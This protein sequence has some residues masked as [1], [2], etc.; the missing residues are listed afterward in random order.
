M[1]PAITDPAASVDPATITKAADPAA[2]SSLIDPAVSSSSPDDPATSS[3]A[4]A[5]A[6]PST[7]SGAADPATSSS[8]SDPTTS[9]EPQTSMTSTTTKMETI[10]VDVTIT[11]PV[12]QTETTTTTISSQ[13]LLTCLSTAITGK[14]KATAVGPG[15]GVGASAALDLPPLPTIPVNEPPF[16][17]GKRAGD[18]KYGLKPVC[19]PDIWDDAE[20]QEACKCLALPPP[21]CTTTVTAASFPRPTAAPKLPVAGALNGLDGKAGGTGGLGG[22]SGILGGILRRLNGLGNDDERCSTVTSTATATNT[23]TAT[24]VSTTTK[25][26]T[27]YATAT[28]IVPNGLAYKNYTHP[29]DAT[30]RTNSN[31]FTSAF[32][33]KR[34]PIAQ[35]TLGGLSFATPNW[36]SGEGFTATRGGRIAIPGLAGEIEN[37]L[38]TAFLIQ[39]FFI[40]TMTGDYTFSSDGGKIDNWGM[41]WLGEPA[42]CDWDDANAAFLASRTETG[43]AVGGTTTLTLTEGDAVPLT[44][45]WANG[46]GAAR[47]HFSLRLPDGTVVDEGDMSAYFVRACNDGVFV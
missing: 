6:A 1:F 11:I 16:G 26:E 24:S 38:D 13:N 41:L 40:A 46:G 31:P 3:D 29:F 7:S 39:A 47:S 18:P 20:I 5:T 12:V 17:F 45:L 33:K 19:I 22:V 23:V 42:Y 4:A 15:A 14:P 34:S 10:S 44:W 37:T 32:F 2:T 43:G 25:V 27:A 9:S 36:P 30:D 21:S 8:P 28:S 35:G